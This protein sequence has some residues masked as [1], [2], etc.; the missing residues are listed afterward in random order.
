MAA[1]A[2][3]A[4]PNPT[5]ASAKQKKNLDPSSLLDLEDLLFVVR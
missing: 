2:L 5:A 4:L 1:A 3:C